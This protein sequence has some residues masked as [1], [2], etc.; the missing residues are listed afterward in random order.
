[1]KKTYV[2]KMSRLVRKET[3]LESECYSEPQKCHV[4]VL[5]L[6]LLSQQYFGSLDAALSFHSING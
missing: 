5:L 1:M 3:I 2:N 6:L 4:M